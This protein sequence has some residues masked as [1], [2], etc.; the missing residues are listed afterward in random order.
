MNI[1]LEYKAAVRQLND[2]FRTTLAGGTLLLTAGIIA[3]GAEA[4]AEIVSAVRA[5]STFNQ[6]NDPWGEHDFGALEFRDQRVFFKID[7]YDPT[8]AMHSVDPTDPTRTE[9]VMTIMLADEY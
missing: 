8:R 2:E 4:Q 1:D 7:Y 6:D 5:F 9:R 3:L